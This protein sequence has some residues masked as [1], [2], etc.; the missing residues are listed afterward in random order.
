MQCQKKKEKKEKKRNTRARRND[1]NIFNFRRLCVCVYTQQLNDINVFIRKSVRVF[2]R[3]YL[4][5]R[6]LYVQTT[7]RGVSLV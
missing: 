4:H 2:N 5:R 7:A 3:L 6:L 1:G